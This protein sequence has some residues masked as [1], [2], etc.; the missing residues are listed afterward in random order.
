V[1]ARAM[2]PGAEWRIAATILPIGL[3]HRVMQGQSLFDAPPPAVGPVLAAD[4]RYE[5]K[6]LRTTART[7]DDH[8]AL[9]GRR[10]D[11]DVMVRRAMARRHD[12]GQA[13]RSI[14]L[15][16]MDQGQQA[17]APAGTAR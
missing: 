12:A 4:A 7:T 14:H 9:T 17:A 10:A 1:L 5:A 2:R 6:A 15:T 3:G 8:P 13:P 11:P 16:P